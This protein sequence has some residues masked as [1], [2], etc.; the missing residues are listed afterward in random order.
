MARMFPT[1][2]QP[3]YINMKTF[4]KA[5]TLVAMITL[6]ASMTSPVFAATS[7]VPT[8]KSNAAHT[9][10]FEKRLH[11]INSMDMSILSNKEKRALRK[12][13]KHIEKQMNSGGIY[14]SVGAIIIIVLLLIILL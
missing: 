5:T 4:I 1:S 11:E 9:E 2:Y 14:L 12:E 6:A 3:T 10:N 8:E 13:V 7:I